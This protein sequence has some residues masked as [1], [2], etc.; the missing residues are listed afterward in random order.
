MVPVLQR[1]HVEVEWAEPPGR[2]SHKLGWD[3]KVREGS[4]PSVSMVATM[5]SVEEQFR[6]GD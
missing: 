2:S 3:G 5:Y 4:A 1:S 6:P